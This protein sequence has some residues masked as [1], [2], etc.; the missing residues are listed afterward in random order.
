MA[1][2]SNNTRELAEKYSCDLYGEIGNAILPEVKQEYDKQVEKQRG[3]ISRL[4]D[5]DASVIKRR[6]IGGNEIITY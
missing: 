3:K 5:F 6:L 4:E 2:V 1:V